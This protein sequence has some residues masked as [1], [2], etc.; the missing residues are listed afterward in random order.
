MGIGWIPK[1]DTLAKKISTALLGFKPLL[2]HHH[3]QNTERYGVVIR[4]PASNSEGWLM[5]WL[6]CSQDDFVI[7]DCQHT[8]Q[9]VRRCIQKFPDWPPGAR[10]ANGTA[11]CHYV[12]LY[13]YFMSQSS[14]FW[15]FNP[16]CSFST[17]VYCCSLFRYRLRPETFGYSLVYL[18]E[19]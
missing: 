1:S 8:E 2:H 19:L 7:C 15:R 6:I 5:D 17:S 3:V 4:T 16:L 13:R 10:T 12:Q 11:L 14:E 9:I 18:S